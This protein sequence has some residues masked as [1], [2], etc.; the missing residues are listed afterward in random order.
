MTN[1]TIVFTWI[2]MIMTIVTLLLSILRKNVGG[3]L[4]SIQLIIALVI[5]LILWKVG[6]KRK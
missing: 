4:L 2:W 5:I 1:T 6:D 3:V